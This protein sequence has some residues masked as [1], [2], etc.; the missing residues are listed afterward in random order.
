MTTNDEDSTE[1]E[2]TTETSEETTETQRSV[3]ELLKL[4]TYQGMTDAE[5]QSL[6]DYTA[7]MSYTKGAS[8]VATDAINAGYKT[9]VDEAT[10][11]HDALAASVSAAI[12]ATATFATVVDD[13]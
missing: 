3:Q 6:I 11:A 1:T 10:A 13:G 2:E 8:S 7:K 4:D 9:L 12:N 5:I